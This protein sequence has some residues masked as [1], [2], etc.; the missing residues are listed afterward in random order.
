MYKVFLVDDEPF[1]LDGLK[2]ILNWKEYGF[3]I[4]GQ[5]LDGLDALNAPEID[6]ADIVITDITMPGLDG[7][8]LI[9]K[10]KA[11]KPSTKYIILSGYNEFEFVK[12]AI[13]LGIENY[14]L[15]PINVKELLLTLAN[16]LEKLEYIRYR[17]IN[18]MRANNILRDNILY[19]WVTDRI[20]PMELRERASILQLSLDHPVYGASIIKVSPDEQEADGNAPDTWASCFSE[21]Y[22]LCSTILV[23][24]QFQ[25]CFSNYDGEIIFI[26][27][28]SVGTGAQSIMLEKLENVRQTIMERY[29]IDFFITVGDFQTGFMN[30]HKSYS[31][32]KSMQEYRLVYASK[33]IYLY[34]EEN[35]NQS[36]GSLS[37]IDHRKCAKLIAER[38]KT[39][40]YQYIDE[41]FNHVTSF[42]LIT[43]Y[44]LLNHCIELI[45]AINTASENLGH[46]H[47]LNGGYWELFRS[48]AGLTSIDLLKNR[49]KEVADMAIHNLAAGEEK[50]SPVIR[51]VLGFINEHYTDEFSLKTL[52]Y[53][54]NINPVYLGQ[55]FQKETGALFND[56]VNKLRMQKAM[57][58]LLN[59]NLKAIDVSRKVGF[60]DPNYFFRQF[61][62][63]LGVSPTDF[64]AGRHPVHGE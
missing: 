59:T 34:D 43:P 8:T 14:L 15:K 30:L 47:S 56:Y 1:I 42:P 3:E 61:K 53:E 50:M 52:G 18:E 37:P 39:A 21:I 63:Y 9:Q 58:L 7:L 25:Q 51:Q 46:S 31:N 23:Q 19:R 16:T 27:G 49:I 32:A 54:L 13:T 26:Y 57:Q 60:T 11:R 64:R 38:D 35:R 6:Q 40:L 41:V 20:N 44:T 45:I 29:S 24:N 2:T 62:K 33:K 28:A 36:A 55:L 4:A 22:D 10:L 48:I 5:A 17:E 12:Q